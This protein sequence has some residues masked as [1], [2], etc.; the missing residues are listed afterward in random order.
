[1][2]QLVSLGGPLTGCTKKV[3]TG[4]PCC[5]LCWWDTKAEIN[6]HVLSTSDEEKYTKPGSHF[7]T[8]E[9]KKKDRFPQTCLLR[10]NTKQS[11]PVQSRYII[12][13]SRH[14]GHFRI[15]YCLFRCLLILALYQNQTKALLY[16][17][18]RILMKHFLT[19][20]F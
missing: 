13:V 12:F 17:N 20:L 4:N 18:P 6:M 2:Q 15:I 5:I 9:N 8:I 16:F 3:G 11:N 14:S 7:L 19:T 10:G 1:M